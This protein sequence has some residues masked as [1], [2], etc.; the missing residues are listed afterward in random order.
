MSMMFPAAALAAALAS[1]A[2]AP[3]QGE[4]VI[5]VG[6]TVH[7]GRVSFDAERIGNSIRL[8][9]CARGIVTLDLGEGTDLAQAI[10][11]ESADGVFDAERARAAVSVHWAAQRFYDYLQNSFGWRGWDGRGGPLVQYVH[12]GH[13]HFNASFNEGYVLYGDGGAFNSTPIVSLDY[14]GHEV[15]HGISARTAALAYSGES[16]ALNESFS[17]IIGKAFQHFAFPERG[18]DWVMFADIY[19]DVGMSTRS[20]AHPYAVATPRDAT[21]LDFIAGRSRRGEETVL[22][23]VAQT[24]LGP[25]WDFGRADGQ[26]FYI[27]A[28]PNNFWFYLLA[29][30]GEGVNDIGHAYAVNGIGIEK[31]ASIAWRSLT[32]YLRS[33]ATYLDAR[34]ASE[35]AAIDLFGAHSAELESVIAAWQAVEVNEANFSRMPRYRREVTLIEGRR[36]GAEGAPVR[37]AAAAPDFPGAV[38]AV[39]SG[40]VLHSSSAVRTYGDFLGWQNWAAA[41]G[42]AYEIRFTRRGGRA[43]YRNV[44][45]EAGERGVPFEVWDLGQDLS[46]AAD[47]VRFVPIVYDI[48]EN[49]GFGLWSQDR[50]GEAYTRDH[51]ALSGARDYWTDMIHIAAPLDLSPGQAGYEE[52][53]RQGAGAMGAAHLQW[54]AFIRSDGVAGTR[55]PAGSTFRIVLSRDPAPMPARPAPAPLAHPIHED[56]P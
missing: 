42:H 44:R 9:D 36:D 14:V 17:D 48:D 51:P 43:F 2:P 1:A 37:F 10:H 16:G 33:D 28:G 5:A 29:A 47:D 30:G 56:A 12:F 41:G 23:S 6:E 40:W 52:A 20:M 54:L 3:C 39:A 38:G 49:G 35:Q 22:Q 24:Y 34:Y 55:P 8:V 7:Y 26:S 25:N 32:T 27:N 53:L 21:A 19:R 31:A 46:S 50:S 15:T 11:V 18:D 13:A 45:G 4:R